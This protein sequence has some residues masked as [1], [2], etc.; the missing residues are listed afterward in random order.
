MVYII[1]HAFALEAVKKRSNTADNG[2][3]VEED[4][5][6]MLSLDAEKKPRERGRL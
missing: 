6:T 4:R 3:S 2:I 5:I 1:Q